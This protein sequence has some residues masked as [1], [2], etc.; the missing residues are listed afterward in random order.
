MLS[1][2]TM[3][4]P[5]SA[6][7]FQEILMENMDNMLD[8]WYVKKEV[9]HAKS[10]L[11]KLK[12][13]STAT[14]SNDSLTILRLSNISTS[15]PL[16][17]NR[18]VKQ[19]IELYVEKRQ[20]SSAAILGLASYYYPWMQGIFDK[21]NLPEELVYLTIIESSLNPM[22]VSR[23]GATGIWQ[24][25]YTTGKM[26]GLEVN[27]FVDDRRDPYKATDAA[28]RHLRDL[29]NIFQDWGLAI[30]AYNCGPANV[31]KAIARA[32]NNVKHDFWHLAPYLPRET[33]NYFPAF[34]GALYMM[35]YHS[36]YGITPAK[37]TI[38]VSSDTIMIKHELHFEQLS[39]VLGLDMDEIITLNPQYKRQV[40]PA[41]VKP[42]PLRLKMNDL[43][44][45]MAHKDSVYAYRHEDYFTP[46][47]VYEN[48][49]TGKTDPTLKT[50]NIYH[51]VKKGESIGKIAQRYGWSVYELKK[52]NN[53][54]T[55]KL[56]IKQRLIVG[57]K[58]VNP[59]S[60]ASNQTTRVTEKTRVEEKEDNKEADVAEDPPRPKE[61]YYTVQ[62]GDTFYGIAQKLRVPASKLASENNIKNIN[63][64][65]I[66]Q[67][68]KIPA[69]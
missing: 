59:V 23:A 39:H 42:Y 48:T 50:Q 17:Y 13:D 34:I 66:G 33:Q 4:P 1:V 62:K 11:S 52:M 3:Q 58:S 54:K 46:L 37:I 68:L 60:A 47:K 6:E 38:P 41:Y 9:A 31:R 43:L 20:R 21:Y 28:A 5:Q 14:V 27:S 2:D 56:K 53:L 29:Y 44:Q 61:R 69:L 55:N 7:I 64:L 40:I 65:Y 22:A 57:Y 63:T 15:I 8:L 10:I 49:L 24:F 32:G 26:Y 18:A 35:K 45:F 25:M 67:K 51:T 36:L 12:D 19:W 16:V 30:S